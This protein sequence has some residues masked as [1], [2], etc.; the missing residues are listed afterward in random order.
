MGQSFAIGGVEVR[1]F[2]DPQFN[3]CG[4]DHVLQRPRVKEEHGGPSHD[5]WLNIGGNVNV[6]EYHLAKVNGASVCLYQL[7]SLC[8]SLLCSCHFKDWRS[9]RMRTLWDVH[10]LEAAHLSGQQAPKILLVNRVVASMI[11]RRR[12]T[13]V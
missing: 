4:T 9:C 7:L 5:S 11:Y 8:G 6:E 3:L 1:Y 12:G 10:A 13:Y 2:A